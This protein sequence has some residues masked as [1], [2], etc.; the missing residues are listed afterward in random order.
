M[1]GLKPNDLGLFD[2][3]GSA[4]EWCLE[5]QFGPPHVPGKS[6][7]EMEEDPG[8]G[9]IRGGSF[10]SLTLRVGADSRLPILSSSNGQNIGFRPVRRLP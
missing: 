3:H 1:G 5:V 9:A 7:S 4:F 10:S 8:I 6:E 2:M